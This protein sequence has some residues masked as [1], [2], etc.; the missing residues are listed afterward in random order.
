ML[1]VSPPGHVALALALVSTLVA[2]SSSSSPSGVPTTA[3]SPA[4]GATCATASD[5]P[6]DERCVFAT[7]GCEAARGS[8]TRL[9]LTGVEGQKVPLCGMLPGGQPLCTCAGR[10]IP[11]SCPAF[12]PFVRAGACPK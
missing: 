8:C 7:P 4:E 5:C 2:C 9:P 3:A 10:E 11:T 12:E 1:V 6:A